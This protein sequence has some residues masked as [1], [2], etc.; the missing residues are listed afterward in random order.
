MSARLTNWPDRSAS[1]DTHSADTRA[2]R[3]DLG[4]NSDGLRS[5]FATATRRVRDLPSKGRNGDNGRRDNVGSHVYDSGDLENRQYFM[6]FLSRTY[7]DNDDLNRALVIS[8]GVVRPRITTESSRHSLIRLGIVRFLD[9][10][11]DTSQGVIMPSFVGVMLFVGLLILDP[12]DW[13]GEVKG[14][15]AVLVPVLLYY[16]KA[17]RDDKSRTEVATHTTTDSILKYSA[18]K[19]KQLEER[20]SALREEERTFMHNQMDLS[21]RRGHILARGYMAVELANDRLIELLR[22]NNVEIPET[23]LT[24]RTRTMI[25]GELKEIES[26]QSKGIIDEASEG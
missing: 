26:D 24:Y 15:L 17:R 23:L 9:F 19:D 2:S 11:S 3:N 5:G 8:S 10:V 1:P 7:L 22:D 14:A 13:I 25:L 16:W 18:D 20:A 6:E 12:T 21:R 4:S